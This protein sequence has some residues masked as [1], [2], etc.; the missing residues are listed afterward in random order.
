MLHGIA[1]AFVVAGLI[2]LVVLFAV[3]VVESF[4]KQSA[5][6]RAADDGDGIVVG[7]FAAKSRAARAQADISAVR[8]TAA[9]PVNR[10]TTQASGMN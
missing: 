9:Q 10:H 6:R 8:V 5:A 2:G 7:Q 3:G 4:A 1:A